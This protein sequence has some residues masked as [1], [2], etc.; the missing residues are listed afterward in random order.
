MDCWAFSSDQNWITHVCMKLRKVHMKWNG[1]LVLKCLG[2]YHIKQGVHM[3]CLYLLQRS[4]M[5]QT[6]NLV[7]KFLDS[8]KFYYPTSSCHGAIIKRTNQRH[9]IWGSQKR[10]YINIKT[11]QELRMLSRSQS[12]CK[13]LTLNVRIQVSQLVCNIRLC[14]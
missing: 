2:C 11:S 13:S 1:K 14:H 3:C 10:L 7:F 6:P 8:Y 9:L 5:S 12:D 4:H